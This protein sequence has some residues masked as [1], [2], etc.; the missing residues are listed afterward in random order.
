MLEEWS[1]KERKPKLPDG[2]CIYAVSDIHGCDR[3][4]RDV[5]AAIDHHLSR[6]RPKRAIHVFLGDYIDRG[7]AS[8]QVID[9]L[10]DRGDRYESIFLK[11]NHEAMLF[12]LLRD[13]ATFAD[14]KNCCGL[15][16][17]ISYGLTPS[18]SPGVEEQ[19]AIITALAHR[20]PHPIGASLTN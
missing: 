4:L 6:A 20:I 16:T 3:Q 1:A 10:I 13:P 17:L 18:A 2:I 9:L 11:G 15:Q 14:W 7:P 8:R 5:F 12:E 19:R